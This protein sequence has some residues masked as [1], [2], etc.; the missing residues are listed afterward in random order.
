M[1]QLTK[2]RVISLGASGREEARRHLLTSP[3]LPE[4]KSP[5]GPSE[6][7]VP[8]SYHLLLYARKMSPNPAKA[9]AMISVN[10]FILAAWSLGPM[11][12]RTLMFRFGNSEAGC[13]G[14]FRV[15]TEIVAFPR[16][17]R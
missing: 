4:R 2:V 8:L 9:H 13:L 12:I 6:R 7:I 15:A 14:G 16:L 11:A 3:Q 17:C 10:L 5:P 1:I